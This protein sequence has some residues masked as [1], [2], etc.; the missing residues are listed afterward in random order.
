MK[1]LC[2]LCENDVVNKARERSKTFLN[3]DVLNIPVFASGELPATHWLCHL[4]TTD[5]GYAKFMEMQL[6]TTIEESGLRDFLSKHKLK[7]IRINERAKS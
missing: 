2:I 4:L 5:G 3:G 6:Y 1:R 7:I